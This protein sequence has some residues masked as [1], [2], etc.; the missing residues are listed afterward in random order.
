MALVTYV[1]GVLAD[2]IGGSEATK[3]QVNQS[4]PW[5]H[6]EQDIAWSQWQSRTTAA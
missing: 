5:L 2:M 3:P 6:V 1:A 4:W